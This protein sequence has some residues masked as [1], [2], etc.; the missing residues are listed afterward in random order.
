[1]NHLKIVF[2]FKQR[3]PGTTLTHACQDDKTV[4]LCGIQ[5]PT[6]WYDDDWATGPECKNCA[7]LLAAHGLMD[8]ITILEQK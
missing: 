5:I 2:G 6:D 7:K 8:R 3:G 1:M 4:T